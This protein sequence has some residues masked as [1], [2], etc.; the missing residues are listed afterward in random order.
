SEPEVAPGGP[1]EAVEPGEAGDPLVEDR[2]SEH[3]VVPANR[4]EPAVVGPVRV[5]GREDG[6]VGDPGI[7]GAVPAVDLD[8]RQDGGEEG[9]VN[10][11][12]VDDVAGLD[13]VAVSHRCDEHT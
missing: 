11:S 2:V 13:T 7:E 10:V 5:R 3:A 8:A 6:V 9:S 4:L 1:G 12:D